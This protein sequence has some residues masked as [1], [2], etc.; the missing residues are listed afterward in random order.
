MAGAAGVL[1]ERLLAAYDV[2]R[3]GGRGI[4]VAAAGGAARLL[5]GRLRISLW[6]QIRQTLQKGHYIPYLLLLKAKLP[7]GHT[8]EAN[9]VAGDPVQLTRMERL[10]SIHERTGQRLH[11]LS[12]ITLRN[13]GR[14]MALYALFIET[15]GA[16]PD[17]GFVLQRR[18]GDVTRMQANGA[19]HGYLKHRKNGL[20][21]LARCADVV[22]TSPN[23]TRSADSTQDG[24]RSNRGED[25]AGCAHGIWPIVYVLRRCALCVLSLFIPI[26]MPGL[27]SACSGEPT[28]LHTLQDPQQAA[29]GKLLLAQYQCGSCHT[30]PG[31]AASRGIVG[32]TLQAFSK[33]SYI[34][35]TVP[36]QSAAL[37]RWIVDPKALIPATTMPAMGVSPMDARAMAAYLHTLK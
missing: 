25:G 33:R 15:G 32:P 21:M 2:W 6:R 28:Q 16:S 5:L 19:V 27:L 35:G 13:A 18:G 10:R 4:N 23:E 24:E 22:E 17:H 29:R 1:V 12:D 37:A 11:A 8:R 36:N 9:A 26:V 20:Q 3:S 31:V 7:R 34:G 14:A 30:I